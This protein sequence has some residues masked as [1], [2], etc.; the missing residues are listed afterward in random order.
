MEQFHVL[1]CMNFVGVNHIID[2]GKQIG[3]G[4]LKT[5]APLE[6]ICKGHIEN[7]A[8]WIYFRRSYND[9]CSTIT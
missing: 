3:L 1:S 2:L 7:A 9:Y 8:L 6:T 4:R 5:M